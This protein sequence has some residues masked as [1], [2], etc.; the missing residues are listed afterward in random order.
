LN[1][2]KFGFHAAKRLPPYLQFNLLT[3]DDAVPLLRLVGVP[4]ARVF[5]FV[6]SRPWN[7]LA[8]R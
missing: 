7:A 1:L 4:A 3:G 2:M 5:H 8:P 6:N